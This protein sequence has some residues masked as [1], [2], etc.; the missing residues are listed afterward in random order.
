MRNYYVHGD[1]NAI[2]DRCG[3]QYKGSALREEWTGLMVC[4]SC[5]EPR[6]PQ[7]LLRVRE[8]DPTTP[9]SRPEPED[10]FIT[11]GDTI[12]TE[13]ELFISAEDGS[14]LLTET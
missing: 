6:H 10:T 14:F 3:F 5:W 4:T 8:N 12:L 13:T 2:C 11:P 9:W 1:W 7:T